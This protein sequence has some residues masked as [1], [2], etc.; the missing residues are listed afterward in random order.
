MEPSIRLDSISL[1]LAR[2]YREANDEHRRRVV[3]ATCS[4]AVAQAGLQGDE[5]D[6]AFGFLRNEKIEQPDLRQRLDRL[7]AQLDDEYFKLSEEA[8]TAPPEALLIFRKARAAAALGFALSS[9]PGQ[10]HEAVYEAIIASGNQAE[11]ARAA[12][13]LLKAG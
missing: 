12:E 11:A 3:L 5:V 1:N 13:T 9:D 8:E 10:L 2:A 7:A 6:A 4:A